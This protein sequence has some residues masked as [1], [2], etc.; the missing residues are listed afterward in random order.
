MRV[1]RLR[2]HAVDTGSAEDADDGGVPET[3]E[4]NELD[5]HAAHSHRGAAGETGV[6]ADLRDERRGVAGVRQVVRRG[7]VVAM[8]IEVRRAADSARRFGGFRIPQTA[9][10]QLGARKAELRWRLAAVCWV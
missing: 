5:K 8:R 1:G 3:R 4:A 10:A 6:L 9:S 7:L 2:E